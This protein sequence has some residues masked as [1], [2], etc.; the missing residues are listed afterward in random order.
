MPPPIKGFMP[1]TGV[2]IIP[3]GSATSN[4]VEFAFNCRN[5]AIFI[6]DNT[7]L[8]GKTVSVKAAYQSGQTPVAVHERGVAATPFTLAF[9]NNAGYTMVCPQL[10]GVT[11]VQFVASGNVGAETT[12]LVYG[13]A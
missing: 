4:V 6:A 9:A 11:A 13:W 7:Q 10:E 3:N 12:I 8:N 2:A 5:M 1:S